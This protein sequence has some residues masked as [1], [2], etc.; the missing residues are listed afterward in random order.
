M[1]NRSIRACVLPAFA[2]V[3]GAL[4]GCG[5][6]RSLDEL[7]ASYERLAAQAG[8]AQAGRT[9]SPPVRQPRQS[10][11]PPGGS[12]G[13]DFLVVGR[14]AL[15]AASDSGAD[16]RTRIGLY[17]VAAAAAHY[18]LVEEA[19]TGRPV[20]VPATPAASRST[21]GDSGVSG[22]TIMLHAVNEG[23]PLCS[24]LQANR[25]PRDCTYLTMA[26]SLANLAV[27][28]EPWLYLPQ[29]TVANQEHTV[30]LHVAAFAR[31][32]DAEFASAWEAYQAASGE[33][34]EALGA[35]SGKPPAIGSTAGPPDYI[36]ENDRRAF[37]MIATRAGKVSAINTTIPNVDVQRNRALA[38]SAETWFKTRYNTA[39]PPQCD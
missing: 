22:A 6:A 10:V 28:S 3:L 34:L 30:P 17:R 36:R 12:L 29:P 23:L 2:L 35:P 8:E 21:A 32:P 18:A 5:T 14:D 19:A 39:A 24:E 38:G 16:P 1:Q 27:V 31:S 20:V 7:S 13:S 4:A 9:Q 26:P 15:A 37:C 11:A 33:A 25:P